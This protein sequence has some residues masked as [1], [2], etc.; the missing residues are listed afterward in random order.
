MSREVHVQFC[1]RAGV[2]LPCATHLVITG[3]S[4]ELLEKEVRPLVERFLKDRGLTLSPDKTPITHIRE[5]FTF[6]G[7]NLRKYDAKP[8]FKRSK[9]NTPGFLEKVR[10]LTKANQTFKKAVLI[11]LL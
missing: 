8:R 10:G 4:K 2:R 1:E 5:G 3:E 6:L 7:Q 11:G 9:K